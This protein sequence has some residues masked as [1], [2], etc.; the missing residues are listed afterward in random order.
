MVLTLACNVMLVKCVLFLKAES[1][2]VVRC[3]LLCKSKLLML[4][5]LINCAANELTLFGKFKVVKFEH[6]L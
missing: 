2:I 4:V 6:P 1:P 3:V 5:P